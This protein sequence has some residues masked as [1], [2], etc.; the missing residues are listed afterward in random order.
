[1]KR[2]LI[3]AVLVFAGWYGWTHYREFFTK[4]PAHEALVENHG[5]AAIERVRLKV[6]GQTMV[7][8]QLGSGEHV[9]FPFRVNRDA[10]FEIQW[11][12]G[13]DERQ[14]SGGLVPAGPMVQR[15]VFTIDDEGQVL[16]RAENK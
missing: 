2:L 9:A 11:R 14:W 13:A 5:S 4:R 6:D 10:S 15:H 1:M 3:L 16:Y 8:E 12:A 7:K